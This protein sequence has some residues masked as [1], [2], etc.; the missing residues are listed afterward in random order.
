MVVVQGLSGA[1]T[2]HIDGD[3]GSLIFLPYRRVV[4][5]HAFD[6]DVPAP[7]WRDQILIVTDGQV[8]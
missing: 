7:A 8:F 3:T 6:D 5:S 4:F 1:C 2:V